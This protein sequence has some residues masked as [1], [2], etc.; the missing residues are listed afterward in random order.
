MLEHMSIK[1]YRCFNDFSIDFEGLNSC[2]IL[3]KNGAGKTTVGSVIKILQKIAHQTSRVSELVKSNDISDPKEGPITFEIC[4]RLAEKKYSYSISFELPER[5]KELRV[6][7]EEFTVDGNIVFS[8][9]LA[10][11]T[12]KKSWQSVDTTFGVDWHVTALPIIQ[13]GSQSDPIAVFKSWLA[14]IIVLH[15]VPRSMTGSSDTET[16]LPKAT[17]ENF[18]EWFSGVL[19]SNP[20]SYEPF[21]D[22]LKEV[23][24][25][26]SAVKNPSIGPDSRSV[27]AEFK[28]GEKALTIQL[29]NLSDGEKCFFICALLIAI[30]REGQPFTCFW[31]EPDNYLA[32]QEVSSTMLALRRAFKKDNQIIITS[33]NPDAIRCFTDENTIILSRA[34]RL[35]SPI[36]KTLSQLHVE[37]V[38]GGPTLDLW[39]QG[40]LDT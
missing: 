30:T 9:K 13:T 20:S 21:I 19:V 36:A 10:E 16:R 17:V 6:V 14:N 29:S 27:A 24:P 38:D 1:N 25:D 12:I 15:P 34:S 37:N 39:L 7:S 8:R 2:V 40:D 23:M 35:V 33:H 5:F 18:G 11:V 4:A 3:G 22:F 26:I 32:P 31:D 28:D